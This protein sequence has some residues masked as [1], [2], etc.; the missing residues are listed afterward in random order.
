MPCGRQLWCQLVGLRADLRTFTTRLSLRDRYAI[1][2]PR[3]LRYQLLQDTGP[4]RAPRP[5]DGHA[6]GGGLALRPLHLRMLV[7]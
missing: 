1:A 6:P 2:V 4:D 7:C 5:P 3:A